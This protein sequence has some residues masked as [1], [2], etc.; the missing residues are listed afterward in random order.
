MPAS[1]L[2]RGG[3]LGVC[4]LRD[5]QARRPASHGTKSLKVSSGKTGQLLQ[6]TLGAWSL[7]PH[8]R[9]H[10]GTPGRDAGQHCQDK[11]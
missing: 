8:A 2:D 1:S 5:L 3:A 4:E 11:H 7:E 9:V 6:M 10:K